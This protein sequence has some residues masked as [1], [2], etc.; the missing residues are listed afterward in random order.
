MT[1]LRMRLALLT[2]APAAVWACTSIAAGPKA[3]LEGNTFATHT[4]DCSN[5][6]SR[7]VY[8]PAVEKVRVVAKLLV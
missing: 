7:I 5:C 2:G 6:D 1:V 4:V 8:V 3:S